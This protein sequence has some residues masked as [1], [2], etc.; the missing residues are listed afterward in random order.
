[1][2]NCFYK[3]NISP[4]K[5]KIIILDKNSIMSL[6]Y[7]LNFDTYSW[8]VKCSTNMDSQTWK[9]KCTCSGEI[10]HEFIITK[11]NIA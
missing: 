4:P 1:M 6:I 3:R 9:V 5:Q 2:L 7:F 11:Q 8:I 10:C